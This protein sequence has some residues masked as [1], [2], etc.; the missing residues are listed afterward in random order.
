[1]NNHESLPENAPDF[2][3][4]IQTSY[5]NPEELIPEDLEK[6]LREGKII[7]IRPIEALGRLVPPHA[8]QVLVANSQPVP[9]EDE[10]L[11]G[12]ISYGD[13]TLLVV[14]KP[15]SGIGKG[16]MQKEFI[17]PKGS[18]PYY[19]KE[20]ASWIVAKNMGLG[21]VFTPIIERD[22]GEGA[23][24]LRPYIWGEI[25][26]D[27]SEESMPPKKEFQD[28]AFL[29]FLITAVDRRSENVVVTQNGRVKGIDN[30]LTF[31]GEGFFSNEPPRTS[32]L[33]IIF[34]DSTG[35][36]IFNKVPLPENL[37]QNLRIF[38]N[39]E[40]AIREELSQYLSEDEINGVFRRVHKLLD[41]EIFL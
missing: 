30:S 9:H 20:I 5:I 16:G 25:L 35:R 32:R 33:K 24:S 6:I 4:E 19:K 40:T 39:Q 15:E 22:I 36:P 13:K 17:P 3:I 38:L 41:Q 12:E 37:L 1:M 10:V 7:N 18:S 31:F 23:G 26:F 21:Y 27:T 11:E 14:Y 28:L 8:D 29:D 34:D 2:D